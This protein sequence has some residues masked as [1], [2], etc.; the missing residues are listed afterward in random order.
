[1]TCTFYKGV[2]GDDEECTFTLFYDQG[3]EVRSPTTTLFAYFNYEEQ[4]DGSSVSYCGA[5]LNGR[6]S[7]HE[8]GTT[9]PKHY[10]CV[11]GEQMHAPEPRP[12]LAK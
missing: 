8:A 7:Y 2:D 11:Y 1:M 6:S 9:S 12:L 3:F 4:P 10:G 5:T